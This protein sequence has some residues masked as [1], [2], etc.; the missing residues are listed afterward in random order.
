MAYP[1]S[2]SFTHQPS[3]SRLLALITIIPLKFILIIPHLLIIML[4]SIVVGFASFLG[5]FAV[6]FLGRYPQNFENLIIGMFRWTWRINTYMYCMTDKY[7]SFTMQ[8]GG[9]AADLDFVHQPASSRLW[10]LFTF[11]PVKQFAIIP[12]FFVMFI[13]GIVAGFC[14]LIG[15]WVVLFKGEYPLS[16]EKIIVNYMHYGMR[17]QTFMLCMTDKYPPISWKE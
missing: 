5:I 8:K 6:L 13:Y 16:F 3:S 2:V 1:T 15:P 9:A 10:A 12:H 14:Q 7:P 11:I 4:L 17:V